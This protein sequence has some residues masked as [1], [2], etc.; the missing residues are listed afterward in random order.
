LPAVSRRPKKKR[1][2]GLTKVDMKKHPAS[3]NKIK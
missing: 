2:R 3:A 1:D